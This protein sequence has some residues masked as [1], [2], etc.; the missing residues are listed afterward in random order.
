MVCLLQMWTSARLAHQA[1]QGPPLG[2]AG[3]WLERPLSATARKVTV[4]ATESKHVKV[5]V[6]PDSTSVCG[7]PVHCQPPAKG[8]QLMSA[9][10]WQFSFSIC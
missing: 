4:L 5:S 9:A 10:L 6:V 3:T 1:V 2:P 7:A 8:T